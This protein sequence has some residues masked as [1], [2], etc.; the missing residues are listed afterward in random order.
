MK[1]VEFSFVKDDIVYGQYD[2]MF[3]QTNDVKEY[4][5]SFDGDVEL[6]EY[7]D[8]FA[9]WLIQVGFTKQDIRQQISR[10]CNFD[11]EISFEV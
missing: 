6:K 10:Y 4:S 11:D 9:Q 3:P 2:I 1:K 8:H 5:Y 7:F